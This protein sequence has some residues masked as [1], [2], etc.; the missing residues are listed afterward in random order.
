MLPDYSSPIIVVIWCWWW[1]TT[2]I[3]V[4]IHNDVDMSRRITVSIASKPCVTTFYIFIGDSDNYTIVWGAIFPGLCCRSH[5]NLNKASWSARINSNLTS[6]IS[7]SIYI[8]Q[9]QSWCM[10]VVVGVSFDT[11][12]LSFSPWYEY[13]MSL[14]GTTDEW[15]STIRIEV[16]IVWVHIVDIHCCMVDRSAS[17]WDILKSEQGTL[18]RIAKMKSNNQV[19]LL[20]VPLS[21]VTSSTTFKWY[22][23][24]CPEV[25][26]TLSKMQTPSDATN[27]IMK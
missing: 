15:N 16:G 7:C 23:V 2:I 22:G 26:P 12:G 17:T 9:S 8:V 11:G 14:Y 13:S 3:T 1:S 27:F 10:T 6:W 21:G 25:P 24:V 5:I 20:V 18:F 19:W 4:T